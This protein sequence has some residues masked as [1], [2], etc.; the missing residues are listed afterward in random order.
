VPLE[1]VKDPTEYR[2]LRKFLL[3]KIMKTNK[4]EKNPFDYRKMM[5]GVTKVNI[6][7]VK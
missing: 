1:I 5:L 7:S 4:K 3:G 6:K 2:S